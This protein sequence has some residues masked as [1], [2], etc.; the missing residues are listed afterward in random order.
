[1]CA[2]YSPMTTGGEPIAPTDDEA[3]EIT[4]GAAR[5]IV[6]AAALRDGGAEFGELERAN[7][8]IK[9]A[10]EPSGEEKPRIGKAGGNVSWGADDPGRDGV[11]HGNGDSK[12]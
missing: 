6:L 11:A 4:E 9:R 12:A 2:M 1:M 10:Y 5:E 8:G 3:S 7:E